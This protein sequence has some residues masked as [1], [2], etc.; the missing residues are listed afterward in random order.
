L[1]ENA[2]DILIVG[3][4][5]LMFTN[6]LTE[7]FSLPLFLIRLASLQLGIVQVRN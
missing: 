2:V 7:I 3:R 4:H 1:Y 6:L 5:L